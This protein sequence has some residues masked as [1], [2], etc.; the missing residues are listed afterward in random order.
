MWSFSLC[1][2]RLSHPVMVSESKAAC[3]AFLVAL[4]R[5]EKPQTVC[6][7]GEMFVISS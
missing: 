2:V 4:G 5:K 6:P 1:L 3:L 7:I